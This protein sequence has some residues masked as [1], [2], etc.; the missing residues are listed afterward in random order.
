MHRIWRE[1]K[2]SLDLKIVENHAHI[3]ENELPTFQTS[4]PVIRLLFQNLLSNALKFKSPNKPANIKIHCI[5]NKDAYQFSITDNGMGI[6]PIFQERIFRA[7]QRLK[8]NNPQGTGIGLAI[9][10]KAVETLGGTI[11]A[12]SKLGVGSVF[13]FTIP[14]Q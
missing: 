7:F 12:K 14:K 3:E 5:E 9:C 6:N 8:K 10:K 13:C 1:V 11:W 2:T 4:M